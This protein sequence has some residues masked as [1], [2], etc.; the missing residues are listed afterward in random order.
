[1]LYKNKGARTDMLY[2]R[3]ITVDGGDKKRIKKII[4][5]ARREEPGQEKV[6]MYTHREEE[7]KKQKKDENSEMEPW[8]MTTGLKI[9]RYLKVTTWNPNTM[10]GGEKSMLQEMQEKGIAVMGIQEA[11]LR[12][13]RGRAYGRIKLYA[14]ECQKAKGGARIGG[15]AIAIHEILA[16]RIIDINIDQEGRQQMRN[17]RKK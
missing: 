2:Y 4:E 6:Y 1:M 8:K 12:E 5:T 3:P 7:Y 14:A 13:T 9:G 10:E 17:T 11:R 16:E 15:A